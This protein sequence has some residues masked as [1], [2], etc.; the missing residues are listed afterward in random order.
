MSRPLRRF[1]RR[2]LERTG[3]IAPYYRW[4][5]RRAARAVGEEAVDDGRP[6]PPAELVVLVSGPSRV[7]FSE[8][9]RADAAMFQDLAARHGCDLGAG[10]QVLDFG[11]G[12]GRIARWLAPLVIAGGGRFHGSDLNPRLVA[13][14]AAN[15]P[16]DYAVNGLQ[17]PL[18]LAAQAIDLV[19]AHSVLTHLAEA[20][21]TA[22]L[23]ELAR[24]LRPGG[25]A[26][27]TFHD[28]TFA[29]RWGPQG[30]ADRLARE[31]YIVWNNAMEGSNY[32]SAWTTRARLAELA[33]PHFEVL[34][35]IPG[36][37][38]EP[39]QAMAVLKARG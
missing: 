36:G 10:A 6:M 21:A 34:E 4:L 25:L 17:P 33:A 5:E 2:V 20:T 23:A 35:M 13:W 22:W 14:C 12:A 32:L 18:A 1:A 7:W 26:L 31:P 19:Y 37:A 15:L 24:V 11:C 3:L 30:L 29:G 28:E 8:R 27:L 9:G 16:G 39:A 38:H